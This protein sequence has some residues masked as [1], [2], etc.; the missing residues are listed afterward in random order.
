MGTS[1]RIRATSVTRSAGAAR[2]R[3]EYDQRLAVCVGE[4]Q[5]LGAEFQWSNQGMIDPRRAA[6]VGGDV[7]SRPELAKALAADR[8]LA[9]QLVEAG[10]VDVG[11][12]PHPQAGD[13]AH[14]D[15]LPVPVD[16]GYARVKEDGTNEVLPLGIQGDERGREGVGGEN[17]HV[18]AENVGGALVPGRNQLE[19]AGG[20]LLRRWGLAASA[21]RRG[22]ELVE[23]GGGGIVELQGSR[24]GVEN[25][26]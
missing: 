10:I 21:G 16:V 3:V 12:D 9:D 24:E 5:L 2:R 17:V 20:H 8:E 25:L 15:V 18:A 19:D 26:R 6:A 23:M 13:R 14:R 22:G 7:V 11:A 4:R 1:T